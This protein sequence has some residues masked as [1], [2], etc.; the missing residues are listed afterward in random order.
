L[1]A[2]IFLLIAQFPLISSSGIHAPHQWMSVPQP[3]RLL[4][5]T[6]TSRQ[7]AKLS[8]IR[9]GSVILV[10]S[11]KLVTASLAF[12]VLLMAVDPVNKSLIGTALKGYVVVAY[13]NNGRPVKGKDEFRH[14]WSGAK[15]YFTSAE[16]R[17]EFARNPE[18]YARNSELLC[19]GGEPWLYCQHRP[20]SLEDRR[21]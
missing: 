16:N 8:V 18:R 5:G 12:T 9:G 1:G 10:L 14:D 6:L 20:G 19:L 15:W 4:F 17:N 2:C 21:R 7:Y 3:S 13:F 11:L